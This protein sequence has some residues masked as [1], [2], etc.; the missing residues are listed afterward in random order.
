MKDLKEYYTKLPPNLSESYKYVLPNPPHDAEDQATKK[1]LSVECWF[2]YPLSY[3]SLT[4]GGTI[5]F[6]YNGRM[7]QERLLFT[8]TETKSQKQILIKFAC[9]YEMAAH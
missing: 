4:G 5:T 7:F 1:K 9:R 2:P 8:V 6:T 3:T